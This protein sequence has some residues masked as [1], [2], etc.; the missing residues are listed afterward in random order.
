[1]SLR[2]HSNL[3]SLF[4]SNDGR[5]LALIAL[6][7]DLGFFPSISKEVVFHCLEFED[8]WWNPEIQPMP[9]RKGN[10]NLSF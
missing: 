3:D 9:T 4:P 6:K 10:L 2:L 8:N 1:M 7:S 5:C